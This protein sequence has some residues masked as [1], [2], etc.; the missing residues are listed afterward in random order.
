MK[1]AIITDGNNKLGMGHVYQTISLAGFLL[2]KNLSS[3]DIL[4]MTQSGENVL[5]LI[6]ESG[7]SVNQYHD[8]NAIF[9]ALKNENPDRI[10]F[11]KLDVST[12]LALRIK[13]ELHIRLSVFTNLTEANLYADITVL[14]DIGSNFKN[15]YR[16]DRSNGQVQFFGPKYWLLRPEFYEFKKKQKNHAQST[17]NIMLIFGGADMSNITSTVL[18][19]ILQIDSSFNINVVLGAAFIHNNELDEVISN[20]NISKSKVQIVKNIKN[21]AEMMYNNDVVFASPGLS[22]FEALVVG[23][24]VIG[25]HQNDLQRDVYKGFLTTF[26]KSELYK[27]SEMIKNQAYIF[28]E[29]PFIQ[30]MEI[31]EGYGEILNEI[32]K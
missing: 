4:F 22:F 12:E 6:T 30:S 10:I 16:K 19:T 23:T 11:D 18:N 26:D 27:L 24:P 25:F 8:D 13:E 14:A 1:I 5:K 28:P 21:V 29:D 20:N 9:N 32:L 15:I 31:G 3:N 2:K 17:K 7:F